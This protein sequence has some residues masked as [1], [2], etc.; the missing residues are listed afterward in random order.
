[1]N[2]AADTCLRRMPPPSCRGPPARTWSYAGRP[3]FAAWY[4]QHTEGNEAGLREIVYLHV[5]SRV[6]HFVEPFFHA[7]RGNTVRRQRA[8]L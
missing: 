6:R 7:H 8:Q 4:R 1:M 5:C 2:C 3:T